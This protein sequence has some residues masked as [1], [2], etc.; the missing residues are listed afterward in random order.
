MEAVQSGD[1]EVQHTS[2]LD[3]VKAELATASADLKK[4][5]ELNDEAWFVALASIALCFP[6]TPLH[7]CHIPHMGITSMRQKRQLPPCYLD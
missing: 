2:E 1:E 3:V 5:N 4:T 7:G 6:F